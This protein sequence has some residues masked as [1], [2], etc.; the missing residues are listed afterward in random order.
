MTAGSY[1]VRIWEIH[2][3]GDA[4]ARYRVRWRVAT[5]RFTRGFE[6]KAL[7]DA[8][9]A[10]LLAA[11]R[12]GEG[13]STETGMPLSLTRRDHAVSCYEHAEDFVKATWRTAAAKS[14]ISWLETLSVALP[15]LTRDLSGAPEPDVLRLALRRGLN[16]NM[17]AYGPNAEE[18]RALAWLKRAS[19]PISALEDPAVISDLLD[20]LERK[21]DGTLAAPDYFSRRRRVMHR[22]LGYAVRKRRLSSNPFSKANLPEGWSAPYAPEDQVDP[23]SVGGA[24]LVADM[25][26]AV[27][28]V[29]RRQG[30]RFVAFYGCMFYAMMRPSEVTALTKA[31]CQLPPQGWGRLIFADSSTAAGRDFTNDGRMHEH[32]GLKGR[33]RQAAVRRATRNVPIPPDLVTMLRDHLDSYGTDPDGR[34]FRSENGHPIQPS[35]YYR[36]WSRARALALTPEQLATPLMRRPY[37]LRHSGITWRLNSG[38]PPTEIAAW[39]GHSV[40]MLL[41]VYARCVAGLED[42]WIARMDAS[43]R[44]QGG[45]HGGESKK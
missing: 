33:A 13:F 3:R 32:R 30:P 8:F 31:A 29:G 45:N 20:T 24:E 41:R 1:D 28:Y 11:A 39:A 42:V 40:E 16:Q 44:L 38:V 34:L 26:A 7:A 5:R 22:V 15:A 25:L 37:D 21:L 35:T 4:K 14:R 27:S 19:L 12:R 18:I 10:Q 2:E 36:V 9:R 23:R 6:V 43:L 17:H